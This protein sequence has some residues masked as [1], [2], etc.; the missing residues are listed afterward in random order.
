MRA[1]DRVGITTILVT[2]RMFRSAARF[3]RDLGLDG[4]VAAYQG[5]LIRE[6]GTGRLLHH[7]PVPVELALRDPRVSS[8]PTGITVNLYI[9]DELY[10]ARRN[11]E[12][13]RYERLSGMKAHVVGQTE[14]LSATGP[15]PRSG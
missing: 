7:D 4:P 1:L 10:V 13:D 5:A 11:D 12:V 3:A 2:G 6:V 8:S 14:Q 15:P 9:D